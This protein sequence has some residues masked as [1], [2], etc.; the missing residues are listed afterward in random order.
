VGNVPPAYEAVHMTERTATPTPT[1]VPE[2]LWI[3]DPDASSVRFSVKH[4]LVATVHGSFGSVAGTISVDGRAFRADGLVQVA[5]IDTGMLE[6][7][8]RLRG[9]GFFDAEHHPESRHEHGLDWPGLL[10]SGRAV[11]G[12]RVTIELDL[13]LR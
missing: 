5:S 7:D 10:H 4:L 13:E 8:E 3:V 2:G 11:V 9:P 6:R 12:D 1:F